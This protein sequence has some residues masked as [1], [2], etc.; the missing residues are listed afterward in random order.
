MPKDPPPGPARPDFWRSP[1]RGPWLTAM[2]GIVLLIGFPIVFVTG[3]LSHAA[4]M[5][6]LGN[7][8]VLPRDL[9]LQFITFDWPTNP[10]WLYALNQGAHVTIG[11]LLV[12]VLIAKLWSVIP[13]L[14]AWPPAPN[15]AEVLTKLANLLLVGS[16]FF[17]LATGIANIQLWYPWQFNF[18]VAHF[19]GGWVLIFSILLHV[20]IRMPK[21][22][23]A[24]RTNK[25]LKPLRTNLQNTRPEPYEP[26]GLVSPN[27]APA[28]IS[29]RGVVGLVGAAS[30]ALLVTTVGQSVGGPLR[31]LAVLAPRGNGIAKDG[32]NGFPINKTA[33]VANITSAMVDGTW[34]LQLSADG[35]ELELDRQALLSGKLV[36]LR[37]YDLPIACVEGW[38]TTQSWTGVRLSDLSR[39]VGADPGHV[40]HVES[41]QPR[42]AF[43][44][45]TL[46]KN[47]AHADRSLLALRV[48]GVDLSMDHGFPARIIVPALPGVHCT[49]WV[50]GLE[51]SHA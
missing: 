1:V 46:S 14:F 18:V 41:L 2:L 33:H 12:P 24:M 28:T 15:A 9:D 48:N 22:R 25:D 21:V 6:Q 39:L 36:P 47:Q 19:Y 20:A 27:P 35:E 34:A 44:Q 50:S 17:Q 11:I 16:A 30:G 4:Y 38:S 26:H 3:V 37:T 31:S 10:V 8:D 23:A 43:R 32:P 42:G 29:R 7:N 40:L 49:K 45:T 13:K 5:P 51:W